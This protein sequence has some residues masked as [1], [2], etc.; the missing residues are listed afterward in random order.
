MLGYWTLHGQPSPFEVAIHHPQS[1]LAQEA[2]ISEAL[3]GHTTNQHTLKQPT[4][5]V[6]SLP[7]E[8]TLNL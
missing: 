1:D 4:I 2:N 7:W 6:P 5:A 3:T 8:E